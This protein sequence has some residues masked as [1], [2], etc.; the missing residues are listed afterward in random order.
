MKKFKRKAKPT[1]NKPQEF[2]IRGENLICPHCNE[3]GFI[4]V[5]ASETNCYSVYNISGRENE[6][7]SFY[8]EWGNHIDGETDESNLF[9]GKCYRGLEEEEVVKYTQEMMEN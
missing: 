5:T 3:K 1:N 7:Y 2:N 6:P 9:C 4:R 8:A